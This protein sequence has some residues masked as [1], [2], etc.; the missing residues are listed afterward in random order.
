MDGLNEWRIQIDEI[1]SQMIDLFEKRMKLVTNIA[2]YKEQNN[3]PI[4]QEDR[5]KSVIQ[6][7]LKYVKDQEMKDY[8]EE[9]IQAMMDVSKRYQMHKVFPKKSEPIKVCESLLD[10]ADRSELKVGY[11]GVKGAFSEEALM[12]FFGDKP[13]RINYEQF[14]GVFQGLKNG[15]I[16]YGVVPIENSSTGAI[17]DVYDLLRKYGF[18][19]VGEESISITQHLLG[20]KGTKIDDIKEVYSHTQGLRQSSKF[21]SNYSWSEV[22]Q[23]NTSIAAKMVSESNDHTKAAIASERAAEIYGL[24]I[25]KENINNEKTNKTRFIVIG[26]QLECSKDKISIIFKLEHRVGT[27]YNILKFIND[28]GLNMVKIESRPVGNEPWNYFF[29]LDFQGDLEDENVKS[30]LSSIE[31]NSSY[32]KLLGAYKSNY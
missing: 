13:K 30:A 10:K 28:F 16:D 25:I 27:L 21:L 1:D 32:Y 26:K 11:G 22:P 6:K 12:K 31:K 4:F 29:Y 15:E 5:E 8:A 24:E 18:Y 23:H 9:F 14:E 17:N 20:C 19:I 7:N 3:L 2:K